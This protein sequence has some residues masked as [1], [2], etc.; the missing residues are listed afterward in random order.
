MVL[1][2]KIWVNTAFFLNN[3]RCFVY[4]R[5]HFSITQH[6]ILCASDLSFF[7]LVSKVSE[8]N[9][10]LEKHEILCASDFHLFQNWVNMTEHFSRWKQDN[11]W[12]DGKT[13]DTSCIRM[14]F[15]MFCFEIEWTQQHFSRTARDIY[16]VHQT[17]FFY[18]FKSEWTQHCS[19][20]TRDTL[21]I[22]RKV[23]TRDTSCIR[24][25][26]LFLFCFNIEWTNTTTFFQNNTRHFV[27]LWKTR[28]IS[29]IRL[30]FFCSVFKTDLASDVFN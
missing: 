14:F 7:F 12:I 17:V 1:F 29:C 15:F 2:Q 11:S 28:D 10:F 8:H 19:R 16:F 23:K 21:C 13:R 4:Q 24:L 6:E 26:F 18:C 22:H 30:C 3:T 25:S 27:H 20:T 9:I 5:Q